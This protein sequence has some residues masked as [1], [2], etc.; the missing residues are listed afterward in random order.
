MFGNVL[1]RGLVVGALLSLALSLAGAASA[2]AKTFVVGPVSL[3]APDDF[4]PVAGNVP[5]IRQDSSGITIEASELPLQALHEWKGPP[6]LQFLKSLGYSNPAYSDGSLKRAGD[7]TYVLADAKGAKGP[8]SRF[9]LV[10]GGDGRA[11]ILTAYAPKSE[12]ANGHASR[13]S[14]ESVLATATVLPAN[15]APAAKP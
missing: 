8:E 11:A 15:G 14:I 13:A 10:I 6:F 5:A 9:L 2:S 7:Y 3:E 1:L 12:I 4:K